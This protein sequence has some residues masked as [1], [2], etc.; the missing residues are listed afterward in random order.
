[1]KWWFDLYFED[2]RQECCLLLIENGALH[3][4]TS[5][6][7]VELQARSAVRKF[8]GRTERTNTWKL[9]TLDDGKA[10]LEAIDLPPDVDSVLF[11]IRLSEHWES[12]TAKQQEA[13][14]SV[15]YGTQTPALGGHIKNG[16]TKCRAWMGAVSKQVIE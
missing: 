9:T 16:L 1:M 3:N 11:K 5:S 14:H 2:I 4:P 15:G 8:F 7:W 6:K 10:A 13:L 12:L